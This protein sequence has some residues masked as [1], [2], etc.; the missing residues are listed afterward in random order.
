MCISYVCRYRHLV[1]DNGV[2]P[3]A[4]RAQRVGL[5]QEPVDEHPRP[6]VRSRNRGVLGHDN[7]R[8]SDGGRCR[9]GSGVGPGRRDGTGVSAGLLGGRPAAEDGVV[10]KSHE[11]GGDDDA[12]Q[13]R[14]SGWSSGE[15][16]EERNELTRQR[17]S[18]RQ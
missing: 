18:R 3:E 16:K 2:S 4:E 13:T 7:A 9:A 11:A 17:R 1:G 8:S 5:V 10:D 6:C 12:K 14:V 15:H